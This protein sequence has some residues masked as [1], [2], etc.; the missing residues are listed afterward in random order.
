MR[1]SRGFQ[2]KVIAYDPY[3]AEEVAER[4]RVRLVSQLEELLGAADFITVH[5]P[6]TEETRGMIGANE[7]ARMKDRVCLVNCARGGI[8]DE[9]AILE[10]LKSSKS[11]ESVWMYT[12]KNPPRVSC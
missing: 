9:Q 11:P 10:G 4:I 12:P 3:I 8:F 1:R 2:M 5:T 6:L 7:I